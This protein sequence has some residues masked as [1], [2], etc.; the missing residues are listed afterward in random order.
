MKQSNMNVSKT[1]KRVSKVLTHW[2]RLNYSVKR[3][4]NSS[5]ILQTLTT[6]L[7]SKA[8]RVM[9]KLLFSSLRK[10]KLRTKRKK[11]MVLTRLMNKNRKR[12][13]SN[14]ETQ[15]LMRTASL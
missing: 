15:R 12:Q 2:K 9:M 8:L 4:L 1:N 11:M 6:N 5:Q 14:L 3:W 7:C 13:M 10:S